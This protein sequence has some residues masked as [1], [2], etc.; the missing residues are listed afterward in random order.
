M[1]EDNLLSA[2]HADPSDLL[3]WLAL[4]D[5]LEE[6]G[7]SDRAELARLDVA[8]RQAA[9]GSAERAAA[10]GR[11]RELLAAG[12]TPC[13]PTLSGPLG[14]EFALI[15]AGRFLMGSPEDEE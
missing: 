15:P 11:V 4:A 2:I 3:C 9:P 6:R 7:E 12:V 13:R 8:W 14:M 10:E 5:L 1:T